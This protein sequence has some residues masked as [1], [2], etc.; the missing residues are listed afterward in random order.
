MLFRVDGHDQ[1]P[2]ADESLTHSMCLELVDCLFS[3]PYDAAESLYALTEDTTAQAGKAYY[4][5]SD[6]AYTALVN[7]VDYDVGDS[8]PLAS[9]YEK[10]MANHSSSGSNNPI[11]NNMIQ[12]AQFQRSCRDIG[13]QNK[14]YG[15]DVL[16]LLHRKTDSANTSTKNSLQL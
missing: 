3:A 7:G 16:H 5:Y 1:V 14:R 12:V 10:N 6:G 13:S 4:A 15:M 9:W 8:V 11:Q 2:A